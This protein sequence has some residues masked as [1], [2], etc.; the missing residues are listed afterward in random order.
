[1]ISSAFFIL[2]S[3]VFLF[4]LDVR[5]MSK[6][7]AEPGVSVASVERDVLEITGSDAP[8]IAAAAA[9][10]GIAIYGLAPVQISLEAAY[11][12]LTA[13]EV[14]YRSSVETANNTILGGTK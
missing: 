1:M 12:Q 6:I 7:V 8:R 3:N 2:R 13:A 4:G 5:S 14:E 9:A 11:M 10:A